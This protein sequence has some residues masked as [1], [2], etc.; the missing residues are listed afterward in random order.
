M[1]SPH[2]ERSIRSRAHAGV[3]E[4]RSRLGDRVETLMSEMVGSAADR[5]IGAIRVLGGAAGAALMGML[6]GLPRPGI[7]TAAALTAAVRW[8]A[9]RVAERT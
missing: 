4:G 8:L 1:V 6:V 2:H 7:A 3:Q 9:R 5:L